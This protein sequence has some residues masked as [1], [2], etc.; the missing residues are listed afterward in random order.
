MEG[1]NDNKA[2]TRR[3]GPDL[4]V[5]SGCLSPGRRRYKGVFMCMKNK[6]IYESNK[7]CI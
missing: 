2:T 6:K 3:G 4:R 7:I 5:V 1:R